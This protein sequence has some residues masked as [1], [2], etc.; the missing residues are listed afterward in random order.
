MMLVTLEAA[1]ADLQMDH[2]L[3]DEDIE[4][5]IHQASAIVLNYIGRGSTIYDDSF[6]NI[7]LDASGEPDVPHEV[8]AATLLMVR[9]LYDNG[10][11]QE[12]DVGYP[13]RPVMNLL[14]PLRTPPIG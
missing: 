9:Y 1:K 12:L 7:P 2:S 8:R 11:D 13:P 4:R 6:G 10:K 5:K 14:Y 3:D